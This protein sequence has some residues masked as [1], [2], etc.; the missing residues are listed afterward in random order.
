MEG[1]ELP[2]LVSS[3]PLALRHVVEKLGIMRGDRAWK[4]ESEYKPKKLFF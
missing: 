1:T 4:E 2:W 3:V